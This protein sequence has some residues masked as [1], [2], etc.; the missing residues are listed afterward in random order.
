MLKKN[1]SRA[2]ILIV[3][4]NAGVRESLEE[5]LAD[6]YDVWSAED[7]LTALE[8]VKLQAFDVVLLD[9]V[10]P[11]LDGIKTLKRLK[12]SDDRLA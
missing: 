7:G 12:A 1:P 10:M 6:N 3:D 5:V 11:K 4:D 2:R 9:L 8:K